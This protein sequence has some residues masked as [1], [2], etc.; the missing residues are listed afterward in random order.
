MAQNKSLIY[1]ASFVN[2]A[3]AF[4]LTGAKII[5]RGLMLQISDPADRT[6]QISPCHGARV[7]PGHPET[8]VLEVKT[9]VETAGFSAIGLDPTKYIR[10]TAAIPTDMS[11]PT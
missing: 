4:Y 10:I 7:T 8:L 9:T 2:D 11:E 3:Y 1:T 6:G 5:G